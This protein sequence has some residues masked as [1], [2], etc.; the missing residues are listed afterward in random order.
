MEAIVPS[1][2]TGGKPGCDESKKEW[3]EAAAGSTEAAAP[4]RLP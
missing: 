1:S 4:R 2:R 3:R